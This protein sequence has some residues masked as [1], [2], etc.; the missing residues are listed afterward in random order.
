MVRRLVVLSVAALAAACQ[1]NASAVSPAPSVAVPSA[2][3][4]DVPSATTTA[5]LA[6]PAATPEAIDGTFTS[7]RYRYGWQLPAGWTVTETPGSGGVHPGEPGLDTFTDRRGTTITVGVV[8]VAATQQLASW[9]CPV[10]AHLE[11]LH[12]EPREAVAS[13]SLGGVPA[14]ISTFHFVAPPYRVLE[15]EVQAIHG[16]QGFFLSWTDTLSPTVPDP[17]QMARF[18][19]LLAGFSFAI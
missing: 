15:L 11:D 18:E 4:S 13:I 12:G 19:A 16:T 2:D 14:T 1:S 17:D 7:E 8:A 10:V 5:S 3:A 6:R 9:I